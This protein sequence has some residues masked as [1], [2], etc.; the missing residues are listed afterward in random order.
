MSQAASNP[1]TTFGDQESLLSESSNVSANKTNIRLA[2]ILAVVIA[3]SASVAQGP[4]LDM[5]LYELGG[6]KNSLVGLAESVWGITALVVALPVG[7][8]VDK[9]D[10]PRLMCYGALLGFVAI[11]TTIVALYAR[12]IYLVYFSFVVYGIFFEISSSAGEALFADS[13][14]QGDRSKIF[15]QKAMLTTIAAGVGPGLTFVT[16][17][18]TDTN[19]WSTEIV[20]MV[21][22]IGNLMLIPALCA[23]FFFRN[24]TTETDAVAEA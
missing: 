18:L 19:R 14:P 12:S 10:R 17:L 20:S 24:P 11:A 15:I 1:L 22:V 13:V 6:E 9:Y 2:F 4:V 7:W 23:M 21:L 8:I 16:L 3:L 5:F